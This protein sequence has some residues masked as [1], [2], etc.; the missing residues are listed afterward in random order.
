MVRLVRTNRFSIPLYFIAL[1]M[2]AGAT[3]ASAV[4]PEHEPGTIRQELVIDTSPEILYFRDMAL[5][6]PKT[7]TLT[8]HNISGRTV[9]ITPFITIHPKYDRHLSV[10]LRA[11]SGSGA[12]CKAVTTTSELTLPRGGS[13]ELQVAVT[14]KGKLPP[15]HLE[16]IASSLAGDLQVTGDVKPDIPGS[17]LLTII[18]KGDTKSEKQPGAWVPDRLVAPLI[19]TGP[20][21]LLMYAGWGFLAK[22]KREEEEGETA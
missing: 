9:S 14:L 17:E 19:A 6:V 4:P 11:C 21:V 8:V 12:T 15:E 10:E 16:D 7:D 2:L 20:I 5:G 3:S 18:P 1:M 22:K 13:Y